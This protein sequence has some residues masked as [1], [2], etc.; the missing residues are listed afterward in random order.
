MAIVKKY[1]AEVVSIVNYFENIYTVEL[2]SKSGI[3][4]FLP[5]QFLHFALDEYD[6][7]S[8][9]PDSRCFSIQSAP[10][11]TLLKITFSAKGF[12]TNRMTKELFVGK[13]IDIKLPFG[14]LFQQ[15][16]NKVNVVFIAGGTGVTPY[17]SEFTSQNFDIY[18]KPKLYLGLRE[19]RFNIYQKE[20]NLAKQ[21][22]ASLEINVIYQSEKGILNIQDIFQQNGL[23]C[24]YF[25][26]GPQLMISN[27]RAELI[28]NGVLENNIR[29]DD[30]E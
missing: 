10:G 3:L 6:P 29:T 24:T 28:S 2:A 15:D 9:W 30:W 20:L 26:S 25:I 18:V 12:F 4:K 21:I 7:C 1:K 22:N 14:E 23:D 27:F 8:N 17:L 16:Y 5:G 19:N 13:I 11:A